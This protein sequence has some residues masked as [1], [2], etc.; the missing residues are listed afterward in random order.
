[1]QHITV[2]IPTRNRLKKLNRTL[3][4]I[5]D[6]SLID[7]W[8]VCDRDIATYSA[9]RSPD[10]E[11]TELTYNDNITAFNFAG[12]G[13]V[14]C[15]NHLAPLV[16]D[17]F[18][19]ATDDIVFADGAFETMLAEFNSAFPDD[20]GVLGLR[21]ERP[22]HPA[23]VGL[24]GKVFLDRYPE[25]KPFYPNYYH[26]ACQE[27]GWLAEKVERFRPS[28][29]VL[30]KHFHPGF[31]KEEMDHTHVEARERRRDDHELIVDR[32][33][34]GLIWGDCTVDLMHLGATT[35]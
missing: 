3:D 16:T 25:R 1:M 14:A 33:K 23:G 21:Q 15:R 12:P 11:T 7:V 32:Q 35:L 26:F 34:L 29:T 19:Y 9:L 13:A 31:M 4:S 22:H 2:V 6:T 27:I 30:L 5:P 20:D 8:V 18:L 24:M 17:G 28:T 10:A